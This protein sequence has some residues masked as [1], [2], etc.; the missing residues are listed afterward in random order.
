MIKFPLDPGHLPNLIREAEDYLRNKGHVLP[1]VDVLRRLVLSA[2]KQGVE[3]AMGKVDTLL[4][5]N[6][7]N[8]LDKLLVVDEK[9]NSKWNKFTN[10]RNNRATGSVAKNI[11]DKSD[12]L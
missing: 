12:H 5:N 10:R 2:R 8:D 9:N 6:I 1:S 3:D 7:R 11:E 4:C